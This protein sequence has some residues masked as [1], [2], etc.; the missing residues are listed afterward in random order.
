MEEVNRA[1]SSRHCTMELVV[2]WLWWSFVMALF[3]G[4]DAWKA[5]MRVVLIVVLNSSILVQVLTQNAQIGDVAL[6]IICTST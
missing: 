1:S 2:L 4:V 5:L 6:F 3:W